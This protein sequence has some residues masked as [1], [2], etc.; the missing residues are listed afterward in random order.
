MRNA[1]ESEVFLSAVSP[2]IIFIFYFPFFQTLSTFSKLLGS[3]D[4]HTLV[5]RSI[6]FL[7]RSSSLALHLHRSWVSYHNDQVPGDEG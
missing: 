1:R 4:T 7:L 2:N 6:R 5:L 3:T